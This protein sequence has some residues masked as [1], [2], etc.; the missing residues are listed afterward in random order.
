VLFTL[1]LFQFQSAE[2]ELKFEQKIDF[3][4]HTPKVHQE[5]NG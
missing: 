2:G 3:K 1:I 5:E 4:A